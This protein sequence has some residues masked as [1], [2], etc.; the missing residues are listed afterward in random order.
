[1]KLKALKVFHDEKLGRRVTRGEMV[2]VAADRGRD[3]VRL[4]L[5]VEVEDEPAK[6]EKP[7]AKK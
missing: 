6:A 3:L 2:T 7:A 4:G 5:G 1:M